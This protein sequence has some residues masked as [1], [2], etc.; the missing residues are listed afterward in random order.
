MTRLS[1]EPAAGD[2]E[3]YM[4][5]HWA[6]RLVGRVGRAVSETIRA[7]RSPERD[8]VTVALPDSIGV[9][10]FGHGTADA[11]GAP[12]LIDA[13]NIAETRGIVVAV[14]CRSAQALGPHAIDAGLQTYVG[15]MDDVPVMHSQTID[16][17][18]ADTMVRLL[19]GAESAG[20]WEGRFKHACQLIQDT[21]YGAPDD[22]A[23]A[24]ANVAQVLKLSLC[25]LGD[26]G[27]LVQ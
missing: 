15:F 8:D 25:V 20:D 16:E 1:I 23:F 3:R 14:A 4:A 24:T 7:L 11:L 17:L 12:P 22:E 2:V 27:G 10:Y 6:Q 9:F 5:E 26:R 13:A 19:S 18:M 21:H